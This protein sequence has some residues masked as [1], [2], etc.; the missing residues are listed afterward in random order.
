MQDDPVVDFSAMV[1]IDKL[2]AHDDRDNH[3]HRAD[4]FLPFA[5]YHAGTHSRAEKLP[6][7]HH[8]TQSPHDFPTEHKEQ[9]TAKVEVKFSTLACAVAFARLNP[10]SV[11][12]P[13]A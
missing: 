6:C 1:I 2:T 10:Q 5:E 7:H 9:Q 11:T 3:H 4:H 8:E 13:S 12:K